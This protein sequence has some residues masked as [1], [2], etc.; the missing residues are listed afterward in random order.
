[1]C[2]DGK[3]GLAVHLCSFKSKHSVF[4]SHEEQV[5]LGAV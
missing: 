5:V 3:V 2:Y 1:M 4:T